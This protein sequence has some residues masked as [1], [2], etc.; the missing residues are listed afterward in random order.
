M[1]SKSALLPD[2][3]RLDEFAKVDAIELGEAMAGADETAEETAPIDIGTEERD[4]AAAG[5][6]PALPEGAGLGI[7]MRFDML[8][9]GADVRRLVGLAEKR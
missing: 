8:P 4:A 1:L 9:E 6:A 5:G 7:E 3:A 2:I